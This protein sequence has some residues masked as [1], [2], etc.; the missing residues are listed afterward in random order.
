MLEILLV[1][2][3]IGLLAG[4]L[5]GTSSGMLAD[6]P[7]TPEGV[8]WEAV[9]E[10]RKE[11]LLNQREVR[12]RYDDE[13]R[14]LFAASAAGE[15]AFPLPPGAVRLDFLVPVSTSLGRI[16]VGGVL[17]ETQRIPHVTFF[18]DGTCTPFR[19]QV[20]NG[21][22][23]RVVSIDPWTCAQVLEQPK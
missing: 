2:A 22:D 15:R 6:K 7:D 4:L 11:A 17:V 13:K 10:A 23:A 14:T 1:I 16:L 9:A 3:L 20:R 18:D 8:F 12:L 19:L 5:V 21:A